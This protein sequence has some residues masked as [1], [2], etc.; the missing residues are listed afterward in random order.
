M[1]ATGGLVGVRVL[2]VRYDRAIAKGLLLDPHARDHAAHG[3]EDINGPLD[4]L[5]IGSDLRVANPSGGQRSDTIIIVHLPRGLNHA[6][7]LSVHRD[8]LVNIPAYAPTG[9]A[10]GQ[11]KINAAFQYGGPGGGG[12][13]LLSATLSQLVGT[14][15]DGAAVV[16]FSGFRRVVDLLGGVDLCVD[17][18]VRS[19]HTGY[20]FR[21]GCQQMTGAQ[22]LDFARQRY[23]LPHNDWDRQRHQQQLIKAIMHR[24][25]ELHLVGNPLKLDQLIRAIG[26]S[27]T[28]DTNGVPV[29]DL[30]LALRGM[31]A[32]GL[33]GI[34]VPARDQMIN[35]TSYTVLDQQ[36]AGL[37]AAL[38][39]DRLDAWV[40]A[41]P[42]WV[43]A[44]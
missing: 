27:L 21:T 28:V 23:N 39:D 31:R 9:Y 40:A 25:G 12:S 7:L 32:D 36:A 34:Q 14:L 16:D 38:R 10:G 35:D 18:Q 22:A 1:L 8:L 15:F 6:Y 43:N 17:Q 5:L 24:A 29:V 33:T 4:Y 37:F 44:L 13:Q 11:D 19:I 3:G 42:R 30:I 41:N 20:L 26:K 2:A